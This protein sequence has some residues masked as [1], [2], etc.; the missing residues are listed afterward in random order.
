MSLF[1]SANFA[2]MHPQKHA[3]ISFILNVMVVDLKS[4]GL[5]SKLSAIV[6]ARWCGKMRVSTNR[7]NM[8]RRCFVQGFHCEE[9]CVQRCPGVKRRSSVWSKQKAACVHFRNFVCRETQESKEEAAC[10]QKKKLRV[11]IEGT[12]CAERSRSVMK[13]CTCA[14]YGAGSVVSGTHFR[15]VWSNSDTNTSGTGHGNR[16]HVRIPWLLSGTGWT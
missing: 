16:S 8:C 14:V 10:G 3:S 6:E 4:A 1:F 7:R 15:W 13:C 11:C 12:S 5:S 9:P 2:A